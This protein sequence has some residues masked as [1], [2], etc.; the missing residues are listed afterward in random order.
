MA[1][2][3]TNITYT[4]IVK[5]NKKTKTDLRQIKYYYSHQKD[6]YTNKYFKKKPKNL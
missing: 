6:Y 3:I 4:I 2:T 5:K 1:N